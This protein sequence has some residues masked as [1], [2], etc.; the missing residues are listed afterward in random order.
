M[1]NVMEYMAPIT[2]AVF[3]LNV[4]ALT[5]VSVLGGNK[6]DVSA[7][8]PITLKNN[9][10]LSEI[11]GIGS[12]GAG[13]LVRKSLLAAKPQ[14]SGDLPIELDAVYGLAGSSQR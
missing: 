12:R 10:I 13:T 6:I 8:V 4:N 14:S 9:S 11:L 3:A 2:T 7:V 1:K 5:N